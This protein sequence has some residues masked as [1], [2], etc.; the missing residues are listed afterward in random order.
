MNK[1]FYGCDSLFFLDLSNFNM[2]NCENYEN[3]FSNILNIRYINLYNF[4]NEKIISQIF[5]EIDNL[6]VCQKINNI[7]NLNGHICCNYNFETNKCNSV[8][9]E[10]TSEET[11]NIQ[12]SII[13]VRETDSVV[14]KE[15][16]SDNLIINLSRGSSS[17]ISIG[18]IIG[19]IIGVLF[20]I[21]IAIFIIYFCKRRNK[22]FNDEGLCANNLN[23]SN[24]QIKNFD[25]ETTS[26]YKIEISINSDKTIEDLIQCYFSK[27]E[28]PNLFGNENI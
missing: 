5:N 22:K 21:G 8:F 28:M 10:D 20:A 6:F 1:M 13:N 17:S 19:I 24:I 25:F 11:T 23:S 7:T 12:S 14:L 27:I 2:I 9:I 4:Q 15:T 18:I 26:Q 16:N 3:I